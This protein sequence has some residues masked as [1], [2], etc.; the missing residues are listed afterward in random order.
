LR[1]LTLTAPYMHDGVLATLDEVIGF[2]DAGGGT[3]PGRSGP[4]IGPLRL[5][6][7]ERQALVAFLQS[8]TDPTAD[9]RVPAVP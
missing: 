5:S 9:T 7:Q 4:E 2:Y 8:L 3:V 1:N 6:P